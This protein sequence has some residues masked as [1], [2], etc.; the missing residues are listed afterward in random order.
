VVTE[1]MRGRTDMPPGPGRPKGVPNKATQEARQAIA[2]FIDGNVDRLNGWLDAIAAKDPEK[3]FNCFAS[4][5]E[6]HVPK[7]AR[8]ELTGKDGDTIDLTV[9]SG[10]A[11]AVRGLI[12]ALTA[13]RADSGGG[14]AQVDKPSE[15]RTDRSPK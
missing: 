13:G 3:A 5:I 4:I 6:Y 11:E 10:A 1:K 9:R 12:S 15:T 14:A 2:D 7:L 8:S